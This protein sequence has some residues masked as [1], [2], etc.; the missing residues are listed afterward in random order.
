V[1]KQKRVLQTPPVLKK[2]IEARAL[3]RVDDEAYCALLDNVGVL[4][5]EDLRFILRTGEE[6]RLKELVRKE[7]MTREPDPQHHWTLVPTFWI[8]AVILLL[9][10]V[11]LVVA[12]LSWR[13]P[14][15]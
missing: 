6:D 3:S 13:F 8:S 4:S 10:I 7:L 14:T 2:I 9:T 15:H 1:N 11:G 12:I 5:T